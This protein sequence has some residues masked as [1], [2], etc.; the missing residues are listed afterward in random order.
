MSL[1]WA[2]YAVTGAVVT[3]VSGSWV[4][5]AATC[6]G[7]KATESAFWV[8]IDGFAATDPTVQQIGTDSDCI[9][10]SKKKP[11][12]PSYYAWYEMYP[13]RHR[14]PPSRHVPRGRR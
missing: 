7:T 11:G 4:Q 14:G 10:G 13:G 8:G 9:K 3:T 12:G 1:D 6:P 2:G 5:P